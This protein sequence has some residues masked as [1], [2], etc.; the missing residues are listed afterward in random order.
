MQESLQVFTSHNS[1]T[2][3]QM[4]V[5]SIKMQPIYDESLFLAIMSPSKVSECLCSEYK[6]DA[7]TTQSGITLICAIYIQLLIE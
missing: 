6:T 7:E 4:L 1:K 2:A 3:S 5:F